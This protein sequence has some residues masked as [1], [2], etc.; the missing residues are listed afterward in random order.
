ML[1]PTSGCPQVSG[2]PCFALTLKAA[3][4]NYVLAIAFNLL[5]CSH[6]ILSSDLL[7]S[8]FS[9]HGERTSRTTRDTA[10]LVSSLQKHDINTDTGHSTHQP[11]QTLLMDDYKTSK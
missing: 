9:P 2:Y 4:P 1:L 7:L 11:S 3:V 8:P 5:R 10:G 6:P